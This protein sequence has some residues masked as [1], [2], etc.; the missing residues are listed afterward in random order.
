MPAWV[1]TGPGTQAQADIGG[2]AVGAKREIFDPFVVLS[3]L[4][5]FFIRR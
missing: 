1:V 4:Y 2:A 3:V 5:L